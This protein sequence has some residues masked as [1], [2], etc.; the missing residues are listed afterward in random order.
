MLSDRYVYPFL[1][2]NLPQDFF[3]RQIVK[4]RS[5]QKR[6]HRVE[7]REG[8]TAC[9]AGFVLAQSVSVRPQIGGLAH[10]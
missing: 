8:S 5:W 6:S 1:P 4:K 2:S 3:L 10:Q 9:S 7:R